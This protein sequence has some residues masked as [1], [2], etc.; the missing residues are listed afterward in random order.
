MTKYEDRAKMSEDIQSLNKEHSAIILK[1]VE[2]FKVVQVADNLGVDPS[3]LLD[4]MK[5]KKNQ[6][7]QSWGD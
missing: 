7:L 3:Q 2:A 1:I 4:L 5:N 6:E